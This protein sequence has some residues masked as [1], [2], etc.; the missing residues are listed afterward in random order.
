[1]RRSALIFLLAAG[2]GSFIPHPAARAQVIFPDSL[3][4]E[5]VGDRPLDA[6]IDFDPTGALWG[7]G[8]R[9]WRLPPGGHAWEEVADRSGSY[10]LALSP[11][12]LLYGTGGSVYRSTDSGQTWVYL[13]RVY[14]GTEIGV[15][16]ESATMGPDGQLYVSMNQGGLEREWVYRTATPVPVE[17]E[18]EIPLAPEAP[19]L[20]VWPNP[21]RNRLTLEGET[22]REAVF[23]DVLGREVL[24]ARLGGVTEVD[25]SGLVA[26]V[27]VVHAGRQSAVVSVRR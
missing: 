23:Y 1:M 17:T 9:V 8:S 25:V 4:W 22:G 3:D 5:R 12:T 16:T 13:G 10:A 20:R 6:Y 7:V 21:T 24:R 27:Y 26:G 15:R 19:S 14:E 11:D 2:C 18:S